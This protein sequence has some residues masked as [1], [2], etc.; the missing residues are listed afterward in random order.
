[1][2]SV[3][4]KIKFDVERWKWSKKYQ[5][6]VSN[7]GNFKLKNGQII[8]PMVGSKSGYCHVETPV[9]VKPCHRIVLSTWRPN[10]FEEEMTVDHRDHN[11]RNNSLVN[12]EWV[13]TEENLARA[14]ADL[15]IEEGQLANENFATPCLKFGNHLFYTYDEAIEYLSEKNKIQQPF[16]KTKIKNAIINSI[17]TKK[18]YCGKCWE[19]K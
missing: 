8:K 5:I 1:M 13:S 3:L 9:G 19:L 11:K 14:A 2:I 18:K 6:Y 4:P 16:N 15:Y 17:K 10:M 7:K 12:L